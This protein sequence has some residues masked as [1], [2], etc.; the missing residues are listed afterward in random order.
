[1][2]G[3]L[4]V[5]ALTLGPS[6]AAHAPLL[7]AHAAPV[8]V[9]LDV[10]VLAPARAPIQQVETLG[11]I[12]SDGVVIGEL[13]LGL[14]GQPSMP[15]LNPFFYSQEIRV[16]QVDPLTLAGQLLVTARATF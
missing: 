14:D 2:H 7:S 16:S 5:L 13:H 9:H 15:W 6:K 3:W 10:G 4:L 12:L 11:A 1:V 8:R